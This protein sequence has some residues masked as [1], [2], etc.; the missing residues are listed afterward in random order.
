V[1]I[2]AV[3]SV[4]LRWLYTLQTAYLMQFRF[5]FLLLPLMDLFS[6]YS[7]YRHFDFLCCLDIAIF[8]FTTQCDF[9]YRIQIS[10]TGLF[11]GLFS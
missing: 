8:E 6:R 10:L 4:L 3:H 9:Y 11:S 7:Q 5:N 2:V 1:N